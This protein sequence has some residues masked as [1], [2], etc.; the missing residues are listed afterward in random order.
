MPFTGNAAGLLQAKQDYAPQPPSMHTSDVP[1]ALE[2]LCLRLL[3]PNPEQRPG[4]DEVRRVLAKHLPPASRAP[5][6][7]KPVVDTSSEIF[8]GRLHERAQLDLSLER[9]LAGQMQC[10][11]VEGASGMGKSTLVSR[12]AHDIQ[13]G[14]QPRPPLVLVGRCHARERLAFKAFDGIIDELCL[15]L[16]EISLGER[17]ALFPDDVALLSRLF[18]VLA[19]LPECEEMPQ[20]AA[21]VELRTQTQNALREVLRAVAARRPLCL[22]IE[23]L[24]WADSASF[25]FLDALMQP[26]GIPGL[27][28]VST[29]RTEMLRGAPSPGLTRFAAAIDDHPGGRHIRLAPLSPA[30]QEALA[31]RLEHRL[32]SQR[33]F[34]D[35]L[36]RASA[37]HPLL[38][39]ELIRYACT[40]S[41]E[42]LADE[43]IP[44]LTEL[45]W[46]RVTRTDAPTRAL[47]ET[48]AVAGEPM[49]LQVLARAAALSPA[50]REHALI[51]ATAAQLARITQ[52]EGELWLD[53]YHDKVRETIH[54]HLSEERSA[55]IH[56]HLAEA[57]E[58]WPAAPAAHLAHH[59]LAAGERARAIDYLLDA[60]RS[61]EDKLAFDHAAMLYEE[62]AS[63]LDEVA[64]APG[65]D[66]S[67]VRA[68]LGLA[69][70]MRRTEHAEDAFA[71]LERATPFAEAQRDLVALAEIHYLRGSV[72]FARGDSE[73]CMAE[74]SLALRCA[75]ESG[76][77]LFEARALSGLGDAHY[78]A[79]RVHSAFEHFERCIALCR[80]H[81]YADA[82]ALNLPMRGLM[83]FYRGDF[84]KTL[85]DSERALALAQRLGLRRAELNAIVNCHGRVFTE[86]GDFGLAHACLEEGIRLSR[87]LDSLRFEC[88]VRV[89]IGRLYYEQGRREEALSTIRTAVDATIRAGIHF[90]RAMGLAALARAADTDELRERALRDG[91]TSL[92][93]GQPG[94]NFIYF[95]RDA[96]ETC[97]EHRQFER[98]TGYA[99]ALERYTAAEP[100]AWPSF[101]IARA[102]A[103]SAHA[104][105]PASPATRA[106]LLALADQAQSR[107]YLVSLR[108][109]EGAIA[110]LDAA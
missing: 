100:L 62:A 13:H 24:Q 45:L 81:G 85:A 12:F 34:G 30:E 38:L 69:R 105:A 96:M 19:K 58:Q 29:V 5:S 33:P 87:E 15:H 60:A 2:A 70:R 93:A 21:S 101:L 67:R 10:V 39:S 88:L 28:V 44:P 107:G 17:P 27:M 76:S 66:A 63:L 59:W 98:V 80:A 50:E 102:R 37:G 79:G 11:L 99:D 68:H 32:A 42:R 75:A 41:P 83:S 84:A 110:R 1:A 97:L 71:H 16:D 73:R 6:Q 8:V 23:D 94:V 82:E 72:L 3:D 14:G 9:V 78:L 74:H 48:I 49:P 55:A 20:L 25:E 53:S 54:E 52:S 65:F 77:G 86:R 31:Q 103:L 18:P 36:R 92:A 56:G 64:D 22:I 7:P 26:P 89:F 104:Q 4:G 47:L 40:T 61:T 51:A 57:M 109:I 95:Y 108:A 90:N 46:H 106:A 43:G 91:E 35:L